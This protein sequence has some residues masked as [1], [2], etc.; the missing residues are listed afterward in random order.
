MW[1][2]VNFGNEK[3]SYTVLEITNKK[4]IYFSGQRTMHHVRETNMMLKDVTLWYV[5]VHSIIS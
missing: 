2:Q 4:P 5:F 3:K 1:K